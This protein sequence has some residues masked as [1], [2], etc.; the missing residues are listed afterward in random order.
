[1][2]GPGYWMHETSGILKPAVER[3]LKGQ[4]LNESDIAVLRAYLR[5]WIYQGVW[6][7]ADIEQLRSMVEGLV[8]R[9]AI[10][11]WSNLACDAGIDPW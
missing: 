4:E 9:D 3:Y 10:H 8:S 6:R 1:M 11:K 5:Q 2:N 7:G